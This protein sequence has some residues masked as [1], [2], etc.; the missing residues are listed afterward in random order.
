MRTLFRAMSMP[1]P[2]STGISGTKMSAK[3][4]RKRTN[5]EER[6]SAT[7]LSS[8]LET[9]LT[10]SGARWAKTRSTSPARR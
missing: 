3:T 5:H 9:S 7:C 4:L 2:T 1:P 8:S 10:P 6:W